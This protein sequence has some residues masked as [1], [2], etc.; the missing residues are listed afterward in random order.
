[1]RQGWAREM[2]RSESGGSGKDGKREDGWRGA[3]DRVWRRK[4]RGGDSAAG[5]AGRKK[6]GPPG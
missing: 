5:C 3:I 1:M 4:G 2:G 6:F